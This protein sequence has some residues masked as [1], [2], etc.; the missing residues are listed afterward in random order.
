MQVLAT[1]FVKELLVGT[2]E[3]PREGQPEMLQAGGPRKFQG[4]NEGASGR[5]T[6]HL[7]FF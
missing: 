1:L 7:L 3:E 2:R 5:L 4:A 6:R